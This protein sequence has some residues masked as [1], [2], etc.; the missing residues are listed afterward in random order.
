MMLAPLLA[1]VPSASSDPVDVDNPDY[2]R[3][4]FWNLDEPS[5]YQTANVT[6]EGGRASLAWQAESAM[7][8]TEGDFASGSLL[9]MDTTSQ[10]G[11]VVLDETTTFTSVLDLNPDEVTGWDTFINEDRANDN[12]G[13]DKDLRL[14]SEIGK[15]MR[16]LMR[17]DVDP[18]PSSAVVNSAVLS[19][20]EVSG[21]K[22]DDVTFSIHA[23]DR[24]FVEEEVTWTKPSVAEFWTTLGG[25]Y[26]PEVY[27]T[28]TID[29]TIGWKDIELT[30]L[31]ECWVRGIMPNH[32]MIFVPVEAGGDALKVFASSDETGSWQYR[33]QLTVNYTVQGNEGVYESAPLGPGTNAT[34]TTASWSNGT[35]SMLDDEFSGTTLS[36]QWAWWNDPTLAGGGYNVGVTAP[37]WLHVTGGAN[38]Q[39]IDTNIGSNCVFQEVTGDFVATTYV[40]EL[41]TINSMEAGMLI[42]ESNT[43]W[44][45]ISKS[46]TGASGRIRVVVCDDGVSGNVANVA[47]AEETTAYLMV[48]RNSTGLWLQVSDDGS[49]WSV[50]YNHVPTPTM[51]Q[52]VKVGL[53]VASGSAAQPSAQFDFFRV[54]TGSAPTFQVMVSTGNSSSLSD[55]S[56]TDW[57]APLPGTSAPMDL[58]AKYLRYRVYMSTPLEW[59]TPILH[60]FEVGW[61]RYAET[62]YV[63]TADFTPTDFSIWLTLNTEHDAPAGAVNYYYSVDEGEHWEFATSAI[64]GSIYSI[65]PSIRIRAEMTTFDTLT[66][67]TVET[68][69]IVYG[70]ALSRFYVETPDEVVAGEYFDVEIWAKNAANDTMTFWIGTVAMDAMN[71]AG[72]GPASAE[73]ETTAV[74]ITHA[75]HA[76]FT[77]QRYYTA[78]TIRI[79][80][81]ADGI[82]GL[83]DPIIVHPAPLATVELNPE[84]IGLI[85]EGTSTIIE[86][87]A[88]DE[89]GNTI[90]DAEFA[91]TISP[92]LGYLNPYVG[93]TVT[94]TAGDAYSSGYINVT[95]GTVTASMFVSVEAYGHPPG[96]LIPIPDQLT[97]EDGPTWTYDL[98]PHVFDPNNPD[99]ELRWFVTNETLVTASNENKT[100]NLDLM[101]TPNPDMYGNNTLKLFVVDP[102]GSFGMKEFVVRIEPANDGPTIGVVAPLVV[103]YD[104]AYVY[105]LRH[106]VADVDNDYSELR[107]S[108]DVASQPYVDVNDETL[109]L[110]IEYPFSFVGTTQSVVVTV[111]DG[112]LE[113]S[114]IIDV[115]V[116]TDN[117]PVL[118]DNLPDIVLYQGE[119]M[120]NVFDLD[121]YFMDPDEDVLYYVSGLTHVYVNITEGAVNVYAPADWAGEEYVIFSAVD[122]EGARM[123][124]AILV[125]VLPV[126]QAPW[127]DGVPDLAVRYD[128]PYELDLTRYI[129]DGDDPIGTLVI[130]T[131]DIHIAVIGTVLSLQYPEAMN[132]SVVTVNIS[133]S[134][135]E[136]TDWQTIDVAISD[137][138]PPESLGPPDHTFTEDWPIPYPPSGK[139]EVWFE[140]EEDGTDLRFE[141]FS[142]S[143]YVAV[144]AIEDTLGSWTLRFTTSQD[145]FGESKV[146]IRA[147]DS[148]G[149]LVE[150]TIV[151]TVASSPDP[152]TF[153]IDRAFNVTV[154]SD[155]SIDLSDYVYDPDSEDSRLRIIVPEEYSE[156]MTASATLVRLSFPDG[157]LGSAESSKTIDVLLRVVDPDGMW[158]TSVMTITVNK[159]AV[160]QTVP[161]WGFF[162]FL[163][164]V[165]TSV[166]LFGMVLNMR[167]KPFVIRD[168]MLVHED[169]FLI[170]RLV[171]ARDDHDMDED[172]FTG[173]M[174][175]VLNFV[176]DSMSSTQEQLKFFGFEHYR[177]MVQR[178]KKL[179]AAIIFEG[180]RPNEIEKKL[181]AFLLKVEKIYRKSLQHWTGDIDVD[182]A[183]AN[184]LIKTFVDE[185]GKKGW[186]NKRNGTL[187]AGNG[188]MARNG[189]G[190]NA[191][192][193]MPDVSDD[194][195]A[196]VPG[197]EP[198]SVSSSEGR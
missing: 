98:G 47:W 112:D 77:T 105:N 23:I 195:V 185:N 4:V 8:T 90:S 2:T 6:M 16:M 186:G 57:G 59:H 163:L 20:Y 196:Q 36:D 26:R 144:N 93:S 18:I 139:L 150:E 173:M 65:Q 138:T 181:T 161:Q 118:I 111:S 9:N 178:G 41:F 168:M 145:Y 194:G 152:P 34:F 21:G 120:L 48:K 92:N 43:S 193:N 81:E 85:I 71:S 91:W 182:F 22:G 128:V 3:T 142:W 94:F 33:P 133:I 54:G 115:T 183:G 191:S 31:V 24:S 151:L 17:F 187:R 189:N 14:D 166:A 114:T 175:A 62:G 113:G 122:P 143:E 87:E 45:S 169:G 198:P 72:T 132:G 38:T 70:T 146:T 147:Y 135:G 103:R 64:S 52:R 58:N 10:S 86:A 127:I 67:P 123:E 73:L 180:D 174:T 121:E 30:T 188:L 11:S 13:S 29:N 46:D 53:F 42:I 68:F 149:A 141:A 179:Y 32:G 190:M 75:G 171:E 12:Y 69:Y 66:T 197:S 172:I 164:A 117:V 7:E 129:G 136:F 154:G 95:S 137:N 83:S 84:D 96:I 44:V 60:Q 61:E 99:S 153:D 79:L 1:L 158:D 76:D 177:V 97:V 134:D 102:D 192:Q 126:N 124:D 140:D 157:Y 104:V 82:V 101:L 74:I 56:W 49:D 156:Y 25:D 35:L 80:V 40:R 37:G 155:T 108:V 51:R 89:Y 19:L 5:D 39:N 176:E 110:I 131:N 170:S 167:K 165:G 148:E 130:S 119:A 88:L 109:S 160:V 116:S 55:P 28:G 100:G 78:E 15:V 184:L 162:L 107:L 159:P 27:Y 125:T 63:E 50:V 106:Y